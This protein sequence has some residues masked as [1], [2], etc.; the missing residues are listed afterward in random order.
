MLYRLPIFYIEFKIKIITSNNIEN[1][2]VYRL[3][4]C[5]K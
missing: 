2:Y 4:Y 3:G 1:N 5:F